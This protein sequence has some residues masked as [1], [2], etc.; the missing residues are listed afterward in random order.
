MISFTLL[1]AGVYG[2]NV[3]LTEV[4]IAVCGAVVSLTVRVGGTFVVGTDD[5]GAE[6]ITVRI[7]IIL[8]VGFKASVNKLMFSRD[9]SVTMLH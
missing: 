9:L 7:A 8:T 4:G 2:K 6:S 1:F 3:F 5:A